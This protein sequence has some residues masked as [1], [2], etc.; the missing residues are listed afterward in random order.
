M[1]STFLLLS[2]LSLAEQ[3]L[4]TGIFNSSTERVRFELIDGKEELQ[5]IPII[6]ELDNDLGPG[7]SLVDQDS[8]QKRTASA[9]PIN[10]CSNP[11][12]HFFSS[13]CV[14]S[15]SRIRYLLL[16]SESWKKEKKSLGDKLSPQ[17][18]LYA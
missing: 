16:I 3:A 2:V 12:S 9:R 6:I 4:P 8:H 11:P 5:A 1:I 14:F 18:I 15:S 10:D 7:V 13:W 17:Y